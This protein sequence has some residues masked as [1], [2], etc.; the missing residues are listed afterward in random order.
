M[1]DLLKTSLMFVLSI[2]CV[3]EDILFDLINKLEK[4]NNDSSK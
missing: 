2:N 1:K 4:E 3:I